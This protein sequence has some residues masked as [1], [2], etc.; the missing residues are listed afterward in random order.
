[1]QSKIKFIGSNRTRRNGERNTKTVT[2][3]IENQDI[4]ETIKRLN[5]M[6]MS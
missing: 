2:E 1:M 5:W 4:P 6:K 3:I